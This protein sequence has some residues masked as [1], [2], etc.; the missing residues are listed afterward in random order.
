MRD[1][2][3]NQSNKL[4]VE[5]DGGNVWD[6]WKEVETLPAKKDQAFPVE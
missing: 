3:M 1:F 6:R 2:K 5:N 4:N